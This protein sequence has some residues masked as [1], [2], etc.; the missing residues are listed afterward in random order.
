MKKKIKDSFDEEKKRSS[1][2]V[3]EP[4]KSKYISFKQAGILESPVNLCVTYDP[5]KFGPFIIVQL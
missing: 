1:Q 2:I 5:T 3:E 4:K